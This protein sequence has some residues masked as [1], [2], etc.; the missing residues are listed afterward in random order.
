MIVK[1]FTDDINMEFGFDKC[2]KATFKRS[3]QT[4]T[5]L[6]F[7]SYHLIRRT[8][9]ILQNNNFRI[10]DMNLKHPED[11]LLQ[12]VWEHEKRKKLYSI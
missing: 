1:K 12:L 5:S 9:N 6:N 4:S 10:G 7:T 11:T 3:N 2:A 8:L